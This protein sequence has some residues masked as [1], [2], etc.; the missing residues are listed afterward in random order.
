M[1]EVGV[2]PVVLRRPGSWHNSLSHAVTCFY[3]EQPDAA[4][5]GGARRVTYQGNAYWKR[6]SAT[7]K[8]KAPPRARSPNNAISGNRLAVAGSV[9]PSAIIGA[10]ATTGAATTSVSAG[11][12]VTT[13]ASCTSS[14]VGLTA[15]IGALLNCATI[16]ASTDLIGSAT[17][18]G[19]STG[20][21]R[22]GVLE[23]LASIIALA[24]G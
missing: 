15:M 18:R 2:A 13:S 24:F 17:S 7:R 6:F 4:R 5:A 12:G 10:A 23:A 14:P 3:S 22:T 9:F 19:S 20:V 1:A 21:Y 11:G 8:A 16:G